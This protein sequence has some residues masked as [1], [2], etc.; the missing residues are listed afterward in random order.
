MTAA[1]EQVIR[2]CKRGHRITTETAYVNP[3]GHIE[4]KKCRASATRRWELSAKPTLKEEDAR[5][6]I[7]AL[8]NGASKQLITRGYR[9]KTTDRHPGGARKNKKIASRICSFYGLRNFCKRHPQFG[10]LVEKLAAENAKKACSLGRPRKTYA[11]PL[12]GKNGA[13][14]A[15]LSVHHATRSVFEAIRDDVRGEMILALAEGRL[16]KAEIEER[17][18]DFVALVNRR[19]RNSVTNRFGHVSLDAPIAADSETTFVE[20]ITRGLWA[21]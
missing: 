11:S 5:R 7:E 16:K 15:F 12:N 14:A 20:T 6:V 13:N 4:C 17:V 10:H 3:R 19:E 9:G 21:P 18:S 1:S 2:I 8:N